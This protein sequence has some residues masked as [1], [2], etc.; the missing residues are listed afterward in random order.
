MWTERNKGLNKQPHFHIKVYDKVERFR[1]MEF[2]RDLNYKR[3]IDSMDK[4]GVKQQKIEEI[5][6]ELIDDDIK[7]RLNVIKVRN[8]RTKTQDQ[9]YINGKD[10][11]TVKKFEDKNVYTILEVE[12]VFIE[13]SLDDLSVTVE[14]VDDEPT[15]LKRKIEEDYDTV[16]WNSYGQFWMTEKT[17]K[18]IEDMKL[19]HNNEYLRLEKLMNEKLKDDNDDEEGLLSHLTRDVHVTI[20][21]EIKTISLMPATLGEFAIL[22]ENT[23][24]S[25]N[26]LDFDVGDDVDDDNE[27]DDDYDDDS[28]EYDS[29]TY[30]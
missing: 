2:Q 3:L 11:P 18:D 6:K 1:F 19:R 13:S 29:D 24:E 16:L 21:E 17:V 12:E 15:M 22:N 5:K 4:L 7:P 26:E 23:D 20:E 25:K 9:V 8:T 30:D 27:Y 14:I 28:Y 10:E